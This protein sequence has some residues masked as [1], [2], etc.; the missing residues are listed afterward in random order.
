M[1]VRY[2]LIAV[3][4][5]LLGCCNGAIITSKVFL[6]EDV[7]SHGSGN[8]GLTNFQRS[9]GGWLTLVVIGVDVVKA[10]LACLLGRWLVGS[11]NAMM[12]G[13]MCVI[14]GHMFPAF[15]G[16]R[17]GKGILSGAA[18]AATMDWR[19]LAIILAVFLIAVVATRYVSLG[20]V[21][22]ASVYPFGFLWRFWGDWATVAMAAL[23]AAGAIFM[24]RANIVR[25]LQGTERK[26]SFHSKR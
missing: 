12:L 7:R 18:V 11:D 5:Y 14:I 8:A 15:F 2:L 20:S 23:V 19:I 26:L 17:G 10:V 9:Y 6:K 21:L 3:L 1:A 13:G 24:H 25:L 16:F 4:A 22:A